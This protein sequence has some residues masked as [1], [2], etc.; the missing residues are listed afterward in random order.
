LIIFSPGIPKSIFAVLQALVKAAEAQLA[1]RD[2]AFY[3]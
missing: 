3:L 2:E 1:C